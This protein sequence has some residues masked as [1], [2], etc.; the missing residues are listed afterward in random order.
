MSQSR[1][2]KSKKNILFGVI[3][4]VITVLAN[5]IVRTVFIKTLSSEYLGI[6]GLYRN[7]LSV[8]SLAELGI[9]SAI[10]YSMYKPLK[11]NDIDKL[12]KI[13]YFYKKIYSFIGICVL[14]L[15]ISIIP[16]LNIIVNVQEDMSNIVLYYVLFLLNTVAS[17]F[18]I[19]KTSIVTADQNEYILKIVNSISIIVRA[20]LQIL[21]LIFFKN[22]LI[23]LIIQLLVS[24]LTNYIN[25]KIAENKYPYIKEKRELDKKEKKSIF[26]NVKSMFLYQVGGVILNNTDNII[27][28]IICG[29]ALVG[30]YSN[31][32]MIISAIETT[33]AILFTAI[34]SSIGNYNTEK[35]AESQY[36]LFKVLNMI[37]TWIYGFS[38]ICFCILFQDFI[39]LWAGKDYLLEY[40]VVL[41]SAVNFY[42][43]GMLYPIWCFR[44]TTDLFKRTKNIMLV[45]AVL[46]IIF[47]VILG[48]IWG[49]F[50]ILLATALARICSNVWYEPKILFKDFF[51]KDV[52][53]YF[54]NNIKEFIILIIIFVLV[55]TISLT[56]NL[57]NKYIQL[58]IKLIICII[59]PNIIMFVKFY[60]TKEF[61]YLASK[62]LK[63]KFNNLKFKIR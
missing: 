45:A 21:S 53:K 48:K 7:I 55:Y 26:Q 10:V 51:N 22:Y 46:N 49:I 25:S 15:G 13:N 37:A 9:G 56:V 16:F 40:S 19:Y 35:D 23:Y 8:L 47:S 41:I 38:S 5:F 3:Y 32:F 54:L 2:L 50:G 27:I 28:S 4:Q 52:K 20:G 1:V 57:D 59:I 11:E 42:I 24:I 44:N 33:I 29:T 39:Q 17:Y 58:F 61:K 36:Q 43:R 60:K 6:S 34:N 12:I 30:L 63:D 18:L 14:I 31:Y 62:L